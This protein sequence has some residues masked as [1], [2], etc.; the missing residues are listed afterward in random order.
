MDWSALLKAGEIILGGAVG[1]IASVL[2]LSRWLGAVWLARIVEKEKAKYGREIEDLKASYAQ[3]LARYRAQLDR[4]VFVTRAHFEAELAAYKQVF[5]GLGEVKLA[6][7]GTR[8]KMGV[9]PEG[10]SKEDRLR[11]LAERLNLLIAAHDK[12]VKTI[13]HLSP[14][15]P[16]D[17]YLKLGECLTAARGEILDIRTGGNETFSLAWYEE[18]QKRLDVFF[19]AYNA[20][21]E[22]IRH[23]ISTLA[24]IPR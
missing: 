18:G 16:Q 4:S 14:F 17:I 3:E 11:R 6:I 21:T 23:R 7:S 13:E 1:G 8:P 9:S 5:E 20:V 15:Y 19:P 24:I 12:T 10:D 22:A 2:G